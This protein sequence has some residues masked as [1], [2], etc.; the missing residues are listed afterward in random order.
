[1]PR[2]CGNCGYEL[3]VEA[4]TCP[5]CGTRVDSR[6][7]GPGGPAGPVPVGPV[8]AWED[9]TVPFPANLVRSW[10]NILVA[11]PRFFPRVPFD[12]PLARPILFYLIVVIVAAFLSLIVTATLGVPEG[13]EE[14]L[15]TYD[16]G[17]EM[18]AGAVALLTFFVTP[19]LL[20]FG[21]L[22]NS[23]VIHLFVAL[24][25]RERRTMG[26]TTRVLCYAIAPYPIAVIPIIGPLISI[27]WITVLLILGLRDAHR[28]TTGRAAAAVLIPL[29][30]LTILVILYLVL[31][32]ALL[33]SVAEPL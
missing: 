33:L 21:L 31:V 27:I 25:I 19:F 16:L 15:G 8:V 26:A 10:K 28:T 20:L 14:A 24:L 30:I 1:M 13:F 7:T 11:P 22:I 6:N 3:E 9:P 17:V 29:A 5:L 2:T 23:L 32:F 18:S 4:D 12:N